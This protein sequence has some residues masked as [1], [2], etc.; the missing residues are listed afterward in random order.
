MLWS[1]IGLAGVLV[2]WSLLDG[3]LQRW[4]IAPAMALVFAGA[5]V[6]F[7][8]HDSLALQLDVEAVEPVLETILAIVLFGHAISIRGGFFGGQSRLALRLLFLAMP[9]GLA[10]TVG[11]AYWLFPTLSWPILLVI[12]CVIVPVD[13]APVVSFLHDDRIP[14]RVRRVLNVEE[15]YSDGVIAPVFVF[16]LAVVG[17]EHTKAEGVGEALRE[18]LPHLV[19][20]VVLGVGIGA[21]VAWI[22]NAADRR[23]I[24]T[25]QSRRVLI[26]I[27]PILT[28]MLNV[29]MDGNGF[30]ATFICGIAYNSVREYV[31]AG[32][33]QELID[34]VSFLLAA[35]MWFVFGAC[36]WIAV[37]EGV[38]LELV[39]FCV[40]VLTVVRAVPVVIAL[41]RTSLTRTELTLL[42]GL[43]PRG[44][45]NIVLALL[46]YVTLPDDEA[47]LVLVVAIMVVLGS[48]LL[49]GTAGQVL[50]SRTAVAGTVAH[51]Q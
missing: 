28:Y 9:L 2:V 1:L 38:P 31:D 44:T 6:G 51:R 35:A 16:A 23:G 36:A 7:A 33:E 42:A 18:G 19:T 46:A 14:L 37:K 8:T 47:A 17:G 29:G 49:H 24:M 41:W 50:V 30:V 15:G 27:A 20:A 34:D 43:G 39:V 45:A 21:G 48:V 32:R 25:D 10:A 13:F 12:A 4:H 11:L 22:A 26:L 40:L 3:R 5:L